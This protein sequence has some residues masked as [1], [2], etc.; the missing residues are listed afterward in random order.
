M[1]IGIV[2]SSIVSQTLAAKLLDGGNEVMISSRHLHEEKESM[3]G[4]LPSPTNWAKLQS[5]KGFKAFV[6]SFED[7]ALFGELIFN[8]TAGAY[9]LEA[10][11]S[12]GKNHLKGKILIDVSNPLDFSK[13]MPPT[14]AFCNTDSLGERIQTS[15]PDTK[16]VKTL[17]TVNVNV[18]VDPSLIPEISDMF[19]AGNNQEAKKWVTETV[20][21]KWLGWKSII[22]LG[23][24]TAARATEMYLPLWLRLWGAIQKPNFNI[25]VVS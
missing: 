8:C 1:K 14:L 13:G 3:V 25:K 9:S 16:V 17:N 4:K 5:E 23:D 21:Q 12:A 2:G 20:L 7:A 24:I 15:F 10:L 6:G 22:D 19:I 11:E 18:M